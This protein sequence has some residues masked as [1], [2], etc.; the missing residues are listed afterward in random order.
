M[1]QGGGGEGAL[2]LHGRA[3]A[4]TPLLLHCLLLQADAAAQLTA[5]ELAGAA[6]SIA[7]L[8]ALVVAFPSLLGAPLLSACHALSGVRPVHHLQLALDTPSHL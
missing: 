3:A 4:R 5:C 2:S 7:A 1:V 6:E 8:R